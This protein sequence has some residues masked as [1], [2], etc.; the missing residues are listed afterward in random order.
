MW[1]LARQA[2]VPHRLDGH[3]HFFVDHTFDLAHIAAVNA[4]FLAV[5]GA[6]RARCLRE[7][8]AHACRRGRVEEAVGTSRA[9][10]PGVS[11]LEEALAHATP[12]CRGHT[13]A[14]A[15]ALA[16]RAHRARCSKDQTQVNTSTT[17]SRDARGAGTLVRTDLAKRAVI[18]AARLRGVRCIALLAQLT[19]SVATE[20]GSRER[21]HSHDRDVAARAH[22]H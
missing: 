10:H 11:H 22:E 17:C 8:E 5:P 15:V 7:A 9:G 6:I 21:R 13:L 14:V 19:H 1:R 12:V 16:T 20:P 3:S 4:S 2:T 18:G